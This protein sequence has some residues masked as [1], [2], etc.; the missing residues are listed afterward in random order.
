MRNTERSLS[1]EDTAKKCPNMEMSLFNKIG[2]KKTET[3]EVALDKGHYKKSSNAKRLRK[4]S[5]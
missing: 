4:W 5:Y 2:K 3:G 1:E